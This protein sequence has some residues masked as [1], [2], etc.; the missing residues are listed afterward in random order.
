MDQTCEFEIAPQAAAQDD[1]AVGSQSDISGISG[2]SQRGYQRENIGDVTVISSDQDHD[3][4][5]LPS[6]HSANLFPP[7]TPRS[8]QFMKEGVKFA[9]FGMSEFMDPEPSPGG[10][11]S[12]LL[13]EPPGLGD[14]LCPTFSIDTPP[15]CCTPTKPAAAKGNRASGSENL[16][17]AELSFDS[18][19][20]GPAPRVLGPGLPGPYREA[21]PGP[22]SDKLG[23]GKAE[24]ERVESSP[25]I[26]S[27]LESVSQ[28]KADLVH[29][30][31]ASGDAT[32]E[33]AAQQ[34][35]AE[36]VTAS[37]MAELAAQ[38]RTAA[39][40]TASHVAE[41]ALQQRAAAATTASNV[42][43]AAKGLAASQQ[44][45]AHSMNQ[46]LNDLGS[47]VAGQLIRHYKQR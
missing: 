6:P 27:V 26:R 29:L 28:Q 43:N 42:E 4:A 19:V 35:T 23:P 25:L 40:T 2:G 44:Q 17:A 3:I 15:G 36:A 47:N 37:H 34:R 39:A 32:A 21:G 11:S 10:S 45:Q 22:S 30:A 12:H 7:L 5:D 20:Y 41:L 38:Q 18:S 31:M 8:T 9:G 46:R 13:P 14:P 24:T 33:L 16:E 1:H